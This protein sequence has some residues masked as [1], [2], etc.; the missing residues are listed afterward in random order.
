MT[1]PQPYTAP[2][3]RPDFTLPKEFKE[4]VGLHPGAAV[5]ELR[6]FK[7][8]REFNDPKRHHLLRVLSVPKLLNVLSVLKVLNLLTPSKK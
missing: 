2:S 8:L 6:E 5:R 7:E 1:A 4:L 3:A